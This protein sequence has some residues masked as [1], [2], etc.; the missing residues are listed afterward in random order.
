MMPDGNQ[1]SSQLVYAA[2]VPPDDIIPDTQ[3]VAYQEGGIALNDTSQGLQVQLWTLVAIPTGGILD[4]VDLIISAETVPPQTLLSIVGVTS[5]S[6][7]FDQ[8]MQPVIAYVANGRAKLYWFDA[9][10][11]GFTTI[12][13]GLQVTYPRVVLDDKQEFFVEA[14]DSS[15]IL[16][17][18]NNDNLCIRDQQ[19]RFTIEYVLADDLSTQIFSPQLWKIQMNEENRLQFMLKGNL[20]A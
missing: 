5:V 13:F 17:Y 7:A 10:I 16:G 8:N 12:D 4:P 6:L 19:D 18:I 15:I 11:P 3:M 20:Y 2:L 14:G 9:T 1:L